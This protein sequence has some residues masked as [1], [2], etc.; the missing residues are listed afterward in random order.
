[1]HTYVN[2]FP[3]QY[4]CSPTRPPPPTA[5]LNLATHSEHDRSFVIM[6]PHVLVR[7]VVR[8][9]NV[10][11]HVEDIPR[12]LAQHPRSDH[13][14]SVI[15]TTSSSPAPS[16]RWTDGSA[17]KKAPPVS[18]QQKPWETLIVLAAN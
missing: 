5:A 2:T 11:A 18:E 3:G 14:T 15:A 7:G 17:S 10:V 8:P 12:D 13:L 16:H 4:A 1:M 9:L 6:A